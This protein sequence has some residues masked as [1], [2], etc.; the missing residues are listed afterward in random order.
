MYAGS[1]FNS[2]LD[3]MLTLNRV[4]DEA[5]SSSWSG[6][7]GG[8]VWAPALDV[9]ERQDSYFITLD[10][11]GVDPSAID[12]SY[13]KNTLTV[14]GEKAAAPDLTQDNGVRVY[15]NERVTGRFERFIRLPE[16][17]DADN[18]AAESTNG[19]LHVTVPKAQAARAR[20]IQIKG[21][22]PKQ[23]G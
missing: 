8:Q 20:R 4:L 9:V 6:S 16:H 2:T 19:V 5:L 22:E 21:V 18:I 1:T 23:I 17:V 15:A 11:P 13:E 12:I 7:N 10:L 3:R 14:R